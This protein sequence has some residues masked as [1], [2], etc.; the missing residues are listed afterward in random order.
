MGSVTL[1]LR[2]G[3]QPESW[4]Y[5]PRG[6]VS[7]GCGK[8]E[9]LTALDCE[10]SSLL[11]T[12]SNE[13]DFVELWWDYYLGSTSSPSSRPDPELSV[14]PALVGSEKVLP[15]VDKVLL[16]LRRE[17]PSRS[18]MAV[19]VAR[20]GRVPTD[21][22]GDVCWRGMSKS[23][24]LTIARVDGTSLLLMR[25][26]ISMASSSGRDLS[27]S[28]T[29]PES[30]VSLCSMSYL[31]LSATIGVASGSASYSHAK[32]FDWHREHDGLCPS[33]CTHQRLGYGARM[34]QKLPS[35]L[36]LALATFV[37]GDSHLMSLLLRLSFVRSSGRRTTGQVSGLQHH[38]NSQ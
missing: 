6:R 34:R 27:I 38:A 31:R 3:L 20:G 14:P 1:C 10:T 16:P 13:I 9:S 21:L 28:S 29:S 5:G 30:C 32:S 24:S 33:H 8:S 2:C 37:A 7:L 11:A 19:R 35:Y 12:V 25:R 22:V 23:L 4:M 26:S 36:H 15:M 17:T 18:T